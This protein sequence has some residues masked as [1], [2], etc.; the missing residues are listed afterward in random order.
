MKITL[1]VNDNYFSYLISR[2]LVTKYRESI[3]LIVL[4]N[5]TTGSIN[6]IL[7]IYKKTYLEYFIYRSFVQILS[8]LVKVFYRKSVKE[9]AK[10]YR[11]PYII[12]RNINKDTNILNLYKSDIGIA[13]NFDQILKSNILSLFEFG[14]INIHASKLPKDRGI[15]PALWAFARGET[16]IWVSIYKMDTGI[17]TGPIYKQFKIPIKSKDTFFSLYKRVCKESGEQLLLILEE[18]KKGNVNPK[19]QYND[20]EGNY[21]GFPNKEHKYLMKINNRKYI[22]LSDILRFFLSKNYDDCD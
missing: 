21:V 17:D 22:S 19:S 14:V 5:K 15:S 16:E 4:S 13:I 6:Y 2:L 10:K 3:Q 9:L 11:I 7:D 18:I 20:I 12:S 8:M 1:F